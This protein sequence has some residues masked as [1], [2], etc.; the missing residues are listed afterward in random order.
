MIQQPDPDE[1]LGKAY[2]PQIARRLFAFVLPYRRQALAGAGLILVS[3]FFIVRER[4]AVAATPET[5]QPSPR[6]RIA[7]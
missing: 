5:A 4:K 7:A 6:P 2:D 3:V 1:L